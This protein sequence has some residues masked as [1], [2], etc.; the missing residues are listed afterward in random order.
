MDEITIAP[1]CLLALLSAKDLEAL[2]ATAIEVIQL[3]VSCDI[4][5]AF[6]RSTGDGLMKQRDSNGR[7]YGLEYMRRYMELTPALPI[8]LANRGIKILR[9]APSCRARMRVSRRLP[10]TAKS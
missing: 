8:A 4:A 6:Y 3:A 2:I 7:E 10:F 5:A 9:T 1:H